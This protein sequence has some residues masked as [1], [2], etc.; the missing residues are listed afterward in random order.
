MNFSLR[1][2]RCLPIERGV[3][4]VFTRFHLAVLCFSACVFPSGELRAKS[5]KESG[6]GREEGGKTG[7]TGKTGVG[8][9]Q[10]QKTAAT[11]ATA[12]TPTLAGGAG[13]NAAPQSVSVAGKAVG[14][15][16]PKIAASKSAV[17]GPVFAGNAKQRGTG[18]RGGIVQGTASKPQLVRTPAPKLEAFKPQGGGQRGDESAQRS[19]WH[20]DDP[21]VNVVW[22]KLST[23]GD[24]YMPVLR[25][26]GVN[27]PVVHQIT[28]MRLAAEAG[29]PRRPP[30]LPKIVIELPQLSPAPVADPEP[31]AATGPDSE[32]A[33]EFFSEPAA[34]ARTDVGMETVVLPFFRV[35][36]PPPTPPVQSRANLR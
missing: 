8:S 9:A 18:E 20:S 35:A 11:A 16:V 13:R 29:F 25:L 14:G 33:I 31:G 24:D 6:S 1:W 22:T 27:A 5:V 28:E 10:M 30:R 17:A 23:G 19:V 2:M 3:D 32:A 4:M 15:G 34:R 36:Q 26:L 12:V 7:K 21:R